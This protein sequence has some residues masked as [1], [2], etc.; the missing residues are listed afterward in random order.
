M[1]TYTATVKSQFG[2]TIAVGILAES[3]ND[4]LTIA[5]AQYGELLVYVQS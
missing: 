4:A 3:Y 2:G 1:R 5:Q